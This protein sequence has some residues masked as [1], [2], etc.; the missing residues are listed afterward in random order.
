MIHPIQYLR[1]TAWLRND[2]ASQA[3][4]APVPASASPTAEERAKLAR[5]NAALAAPNEKFDQL[6]EKNPRQ[7]KTAVP[8][9]LT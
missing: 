9:D 3:K 2:L 7:E 1:T 8:G 4:A 5:I 6:F